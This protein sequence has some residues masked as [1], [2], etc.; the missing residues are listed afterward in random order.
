MKAAVWHGKKDVRIEDVPEP[1]TGKG[2]V[3]IKVHWCGICG[4]DVHEYA[5]GPIFLPV[6]PHPLTGK[7]VPIILGHECSGEVVEVGEGVEGINIGEI[8]VPWPVANCG[9]CYWCKRGEP[10][11]CENVVAIGLMADGA[12]AEYMTVPSYCINKVPSGV[13]PDKAA[14]T[15]PLS[16][17]LHALGKSGIKPGDNV[18]IVGAGTIGLSTMQ[19][20]RIS[21]ARKVFVVEMAEARKKLAKQLGAYMVI[22]PTE[23]NVAEEISKATDGVGADIAFECVGNQGALNT[24]IDVVRRGGKTVVLGVFEKPAEIN[25][26]LA[27]LFEKQIICS[28]GHN[29]EFA[30]VLSYLKDGR[31]QAEPLITSRIKLDDIVEQGF[32]ELIG[33]KDKHIKILVSPR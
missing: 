6:E 8:V 27:L 18:A 29:F 25:M 22:D 1:K 23:V 15:E 7:K 2:E 32:E 12:Y 13:S 24:A 20:A 31:M 11:L 14:L 17:G 33:K 10:V 30:P 16:V 9:K 19:A 26:V 21:G 28:F 4:T 3:K 5:A